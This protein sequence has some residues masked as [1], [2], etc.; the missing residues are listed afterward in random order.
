ML[1]SL[2]RL[3]GGP[4]EA[5]AWTEQE[6]W[7]RS[8]QWTLRHV[9]EINGFVIE[10]R[11]G[12]TA[13]RLEWGPSQR[14]YIDGPELRVRAELAVPR[15]LQVLLL[16]RT[17]MEAMERQ[18]FDQYVEGVQTRIDTETPAEMRWLVMFAK[19]SG[20]DLGSLRERFSALASFKP[21]LHQ[22]LAGPLPKALAKAPL[23]AGQAM[24]LMVGRRRLSLR[25]ALNQPEP[26]ALERW[27]Q[28]F[29]CALAEAHRVT[30]DFSGAGSPSTQPSLFSPSAHSTE[31]TP[32]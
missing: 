11:K 21:W 22:W 5:P 4:S 14:P 20:S 12:P 17:L 9:R 2:K 31:Q 32:S 30:V 1:D 3:L 8:N 24:V 13:W 26:A 10:G 19:L 29:E 7:A 25:V 6:A 16:N 18:V 28:L 23:G 15:E 27:L